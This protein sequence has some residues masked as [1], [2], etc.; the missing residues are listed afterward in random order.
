MGI[1]S[2]DF[3]FI[4]IIKM[5]YSYL[6]MLQNYVYGLKEKRIK[7]IFY[8]QYVLIRFEYDSKII[9]SLFRMML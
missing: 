9:I 2:W 4:I 7:K 5:V 1:L 3:C 8:G 6:C